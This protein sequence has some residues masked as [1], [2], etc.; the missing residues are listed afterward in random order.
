MNKPEQFRLSANEL[1]PLI[2]K[3]NVPAAIRL[4]VHVGAMGATGTL[5]W[6]ALYTWWAVP[7]TFLHGYLIAF[8][9]TAEHE[10]AHH[11]AFRTRAF[12]YFMGHFAGFAIVFPYE[13]YRAFH[14]DHHRHTNDPAKDPELLTRPLLTSRFKLFWYLT[15]LPVWVYRV[16][17]LIAHCVSK[18]V[19][20][21]WVPEDK[22]GLIAL[23]ARFYL[24]SYAVVFGL[25]VAMQSL[26]ALWLWVIPLMAGQLFLRPYQLAE[27]TGCAHTSN[28]LENTRTTYTNA[29]IRYFAWNMPYHVEHHAYP[30]VPFHALPKLNQILASHIVNTEQGYPAS[31]RS[32]MK[33][34]DREMQETRMTQSVGSR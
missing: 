34:L 24:L 13:Y 18:N 14:W 23:E 27:H 31:T 16:R 7:L 1:R 5:L 8:L 11:T 33:H 28:M 2:K 22:R 4:L 26:A 15:S 29:V 3:T 32:A 25:S 20:E 21:S 10:A 6:H 9:F 30:V 17:M 19:Q 12:N